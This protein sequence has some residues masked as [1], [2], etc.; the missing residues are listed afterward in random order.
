MQRDAK[1]PN[2]IKYIA[3]YTTNIIHPK[4]DNTF[5]KKPSTKLVILKIQNN[6]IPK[7]TIPAVHEKNMACFRLD[8]F[9]TNNKG[10]NET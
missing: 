9:R 7:K 4:I 2:G 1:I 8:D 5:N 10:I 3:Q 6:D